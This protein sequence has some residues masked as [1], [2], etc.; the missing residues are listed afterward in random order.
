MADAEITRWALGLMALP[1]ISFVVWLV[2]L[3]GRVNAH[4]ETVKDLKSDL[5]YIRTRID[6]ALK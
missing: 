5:H 6:E 2:R 3:E 4:D 1:T